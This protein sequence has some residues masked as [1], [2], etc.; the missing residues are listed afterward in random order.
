M[1][2]SERPRETLDI[3]LTPLIDVVF[4]LLIF[5]MVT[6]TFQNDE[7]DLRISVPQAEHG[8][9]IRDLPEVMVVG[10]R[11]DGTISIGGREVDKE[12][13]RRVL[14]RARRKNRKQKVIVRADRDTPF[15]HPILVL[16]MCTGL[17]IETAV[18]TS[19]STT[20]N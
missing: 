20:T 3:N 16:D 11:K 4:L 12:E 6:A 10:V 8:N 14:T 1:K 7:R 9:P 18:T 13:L 17:K 5:F 19:E 2:L 15:Q